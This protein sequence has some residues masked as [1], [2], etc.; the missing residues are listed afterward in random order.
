MFVLP[1]APASPHRLYASDA[2]GLHRIAPWAPHE[3]PAWHVE[4]IAP[5]EL[6]FATQ[7]VS[8]ALQSALLLHFTVAAAPEQVDAQV[9]VGDAPLASMQ[10]P[11]FVMSHGEPPHEIV[12]G[13][14]S[15]A[16]AEGPAAPPPPLPATSLL[17]HPIA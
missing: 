7:H 5:V 17:L 15:P 8:V 4:T 2:A 13:G 3:P 11:F 10:H 12:V 16:S 1:H 9:K 6:S 14:V